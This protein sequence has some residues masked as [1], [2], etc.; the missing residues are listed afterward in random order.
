MV[1]KAK[2][3]L[4]W[5]FKKNAD[6]LVKVT[7]GKYRSFLQLQ[8]SWLS[9]T[10]VAILLFMLFNFQLEKDAHTIIMP[11]ISKLHA[12]Q[13][14]DSRGNPTVEVDLVTDKG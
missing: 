3:V 6:N 10:L 2:I 13:I 4:S 14:F 9:L 1:F 11:Q 7:H 8:N 5:Q 12:R